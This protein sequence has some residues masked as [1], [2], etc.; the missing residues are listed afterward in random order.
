MTQI[1]IIDGLINQW[2]H[3][4][5][6]LLN[7]VQQQ[8][9]SSIFQLFSFKYPQFFEDLFLLHQTNVDVALDP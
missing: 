9:K 6:R 3:F 4:I 8:K 5:D 2:I 1:S 7:I